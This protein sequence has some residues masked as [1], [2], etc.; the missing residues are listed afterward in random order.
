M[1]KKKPGIMSSC[2]H[3][4]RKTFE[5]EEILDLLSFVD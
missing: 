3:I 2:I 5:D 1:P 4:S